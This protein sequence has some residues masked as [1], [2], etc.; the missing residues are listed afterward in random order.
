MTLPPRPAAPE[1]S[2][3]VPQDAEVEAPPTPKRKTAII[4]GVIA[5]VLML[6]LCGGCLVV[7]GAVTISSRAGTPEAGTIPYSAAP[8]EASPSRTTT[9]PTPTP[10]P[11]REAFEDISAGDCLDA[12]M[13]PYDASEWSEDVPNAVDCDRTDAYVRVTSVEDSASDCN[14]DALDA[15][16]WWKYSAGG[17][18][19]YLC[20]ERQLRV[21]ECFLAEVSEEDAKRVAISRHGLMTSWQC[22]KGTVP[23]DFDYILQVTALTNGDCPRNSRSWDDFRGGKLCAR[24]V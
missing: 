17:N 5:A 19:I 2:D 13:D 23:R 15:E 1:P 18:A 8:I 6:C 4:V 14:S 11:T 22:G 9:R 10:D 16:T 21:G 24:V 7:V 20:L 12:Y 3:E